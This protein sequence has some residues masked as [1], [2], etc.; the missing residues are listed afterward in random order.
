MKPNRPNRRFLLLAVSFGLIIFVILAQASYYQVFGG[1]RALP[2]PAV[3][4]EPAPRG[5]VVD[6]HG[7]PLIVNRHFFQVAATP[8]L[9]VGDIARDE[10][11]KQLESLL[12]LPYANT[13]ATLQANQEFQWA[14]LADAISLEEANLLNETKQRLATERGIF[15]LQHV[16]VTPMTRRSYPQGEALAH[17]TGFVS[18]EYG[19]SAE[20]RSTTTSFCLRTAS[21]CSMT[22]RPASARAARG[23]TTFS[24][25]APAK[26]LV[27]TVDRTIQW[28]IN[29][30][31]AEDWRSSRP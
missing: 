4:K 24:P 2:A 14:M 5:M 29:R 30:N 9:I 18:P 12:G 21:A 1:Q 28:I 17:V 16:Y 27:L 25:S 31:C 7:V 23:R 8:N 10:V 22:R 20:L 3:V 26:D 6:S 11:A 15:P 19:A 13:F